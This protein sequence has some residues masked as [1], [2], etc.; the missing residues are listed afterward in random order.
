[1]GLSGPRKRAKIS[2][3][4]NNTTW[5][6]SVSNFGHKI[7]AAQG[8]NPGEFLGA[9]GA[10]HAE[11]HTRA[12]ASHIRVVLKDDNLGLGAKRGGGQIEGQCTGLDAFQGLLGRLNGKSEDQLQKDQ[13]SRDDLKRA[14]YTE[15]RWGS[16]RFVKGGV[17][18][19]DM[20]HDLAPAEAARLRAS[21]KQGKPQQPK[22]LSISQMSQER[23]KGESTGHAAA[24]AESLALDSRKMEKKGRKKKSKSHVRASHE[25]FNGEG[26]VFEAELLNRRSDVNIP[27]PSSASCIAKYSPSRSEEPQSSHATRSQ[28]GQEWTK[29]RSLKPEPQV[30]NRAKRVER[31]KRVISSSSAASSGPPISSEMVKEDVIGTAPTTH[32]LLDQSV[33][34]PVQTSAVTFS[35]GRH[36]VRQRY[37]QQKKLA[38]MDIKSLNEV[39]QI[40]TVL[41]VSL[42]HICVDSY[43]EGMTFAY[44]VILSETRPNL[45]EASQ[46]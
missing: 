1:M 46:V 26:M 9:T 17:L 41:I 20:T 33:T 14:V 22:S 34:T 37:I 38:V 8:W 28:Q 44:G 3:D 36:A 6:R 43:G 11:L 42:A 2:H 27:D 13:E 10:P 18:V 32:P 39:C 35:G 23:E 16:V 7:L 31:E 30:T 5:T 15:S 21:V 19:G 29:K 45:A 4:P 12:N 24:A 25:G 40:S